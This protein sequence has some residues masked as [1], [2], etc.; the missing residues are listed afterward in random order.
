MLE[1]RDY[2]V[3]PGAKAEEVWAKAWDWWQRAGF[4]LYHVGPGH[5]TGSSVYSKIG[6]RREIDLRF[7]DAN[8]APYVDLAFRARL[9]DEG[10]VGGAGA[11]AALFDRRFPSPRRA[12]RTFCDHRSSESSR[13]LHALC[14]RRCTGP[15]N[16]PEAQGGGDWGDAS[17]NAG[18]ARVEFDLRETVRRRDAE[19]TR[20]T[21]GAAGHRPDETS[22]R[23]PRR[24]PP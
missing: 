21:S 23:P 7:M 22:F 13:Y 3:V 15:A 1:K 24:R 6:L 5:F 18:H 2:R 17:A 4:A 14:R 16:H 19:P 8:N 12:S 9:T 10:G 11:A 20:A